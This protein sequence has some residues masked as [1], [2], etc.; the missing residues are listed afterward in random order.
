MRQMWQDG[1][2]KARLGHTTLEEV[3][4]AASVVLVEDQ[5]REGRIAA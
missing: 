4:N 2:E 5:L 3:A 1:V